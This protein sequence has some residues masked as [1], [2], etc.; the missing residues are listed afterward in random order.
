MF[1]GE[2]NLSKLYLASL[3]KGVEFWDQKSSFTSS[4][5]PENGDFQFYFKLKQVHMY[6]TFSF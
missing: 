1:S 5:S 2:I 6:L 4:V 3:R